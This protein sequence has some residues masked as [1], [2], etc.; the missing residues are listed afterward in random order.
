MFIQE[1]VPSKSDAGTAGTT[2]IFFEGMENVNVK[3]KKCYKR[4]KGDVIKDH[5]ARW[6]S[7]IIFEI[8]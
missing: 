4:N 2:S 8:Q 6:K 7:M 1:W 3:C 5:Q